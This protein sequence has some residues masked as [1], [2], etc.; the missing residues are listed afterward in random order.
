MYSIDDA[1]QALELRVSCIVSYGGVENVILF[2][3]TALR[4]QYCT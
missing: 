1:G 4:I 2:I 3:F